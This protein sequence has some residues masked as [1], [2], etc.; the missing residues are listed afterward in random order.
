M[1]VAKKLFDAKT[2]KDVNLRK[3]LQEAFGALWG[4]EGKK[5][6]YTYVKGCKKDAVAAD[7]EVIAE[8]NGSTA[9]FKLDAV[10]NEL[11][12]NIM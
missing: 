8:T 3:T 2:D 11:L 10:A 1:I 9:V 6:V 7:D 12:S 4:I 5:G